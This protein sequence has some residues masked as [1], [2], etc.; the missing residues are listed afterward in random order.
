MGG[1]AS[2]LAS[3]PISGDSL[4]QYLRSLTNYGGTTGTGWLGAAQPTVTGGLAQLGDAYSTTA[5]PA[6]YWQAILSGD[7]RTMTAAVAPT[8]SMLSNIY[9]GALQNASTQMPAGGARAVTM[10]QLPQAQAAQVGNTLLGLQPAAATNLAGLA[11][12]QAGIGGTTANVGLGQA[13]VGSNLLAQTLQALLQRR[14][15][16]VTQDMSNM[17]LL[18]G[19]LSSL[20]GNLTDLYKAGLFTGPGGASGQPSDIDLKTGIIPLGVVDGIPVYVWRFKSSGELAMGVIAQEVREIRPECIV[21][22]S[23]GYLRVH[24]DQLFPQF[25]VN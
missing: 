12:V 20:M 9:S 23:D 3:E 10:A 5:A 21:E 22:G 15:Q 16:N 2:P 6:A 25:R 24:Y 4:T 8:A 14:G 7:P 19:G 1:F 18:T 13:Q 17:G 11:G